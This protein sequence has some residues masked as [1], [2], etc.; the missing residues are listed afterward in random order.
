VSLH[1]HFDALI[2]A[3]PPD[4]CG[5]AGPNSYVET[6]NTEVSIYN[7]IT[8]ATIANDSLD[9]FFHTTG[10]I[11]RPNPY[12]FLSDATMCYDE[13][14]GRFVIADLDLDVRN[15][16]Q[17]PSLCA[18]AWS[19]TSNPT[20]LDTANWNFTYWTTSEGAAWSDYPGNIG[21]NHDAV[22]ITWNM[23]NS[24]HVRIDAL[25]QADMAANRAVYHT[26]YDTNLWN[27]RPVTMHDS[28]A[29]AGPM[30]FVT[31]GRT[32]S[33][34]EITL[35]RSDDILGNAI[36]DQ[37]FYIPVSH[38]D[39]AN[40]PL[41]PDG[42]VITTN[43]GG[44]KIL[45]AA[46]RNNTIVACHHIGVGTTENDARWYKFN[47]SDINHPY[48]VDQGNVSAGNHTYLMMPGI[49]I[50]AAG[51]V[52][53]S[54]IRSGTDSSTDYMSVWVTGRR[55]SDPAGTMQT[56][57]LVRAGTGN[58]RTGR[59][60][61]FSG[62][63]VDPNDG[64]FWV[65]NEYATAGGYNHATEVA[66]FAM[67]RQT[68]SVA[69]GQL[70][71]YGDQLGPNYNDYIAIDV[72][73]HGG[74]YANLNGEAAWFDP[75]QI[76]SILVVP[77]GGSNTVTV[78]NT[79]VPVD[80]R[81]SASDTVNLGN[82]SVQGIT[83]AVDI[84][85]PPTYDVLNINDSAD[86]A[87]H[88]NVAIGPG[89]ITG[90]A[91]AALNF[92][93]N[94]IGT[95]TV[96]GGSGN[97]T[98]TISDTPAHTSM[99]L[100]TGG[101][102]DTAYVRAAHVP[103]AVNTTTGNGGGGNDVV[104]IGNASHSLADIQAAVTVYN[105]PSRDQ[106]TIDDSADPYSHPNVAIGT[107]GITGLAPAALNFSAYSVD[108][109][110]VL[111]GGGA[112]T[113]TIS[114]TPANASMTLDTGAGVDTVNVQATSVPLTVIAGG[115]GSD[116]VN[117]GNANSLA[118]INGAL[119][120]DNPPSWSHVN[121]NDGADAGNHPNVTLTDTSLTGLAPATITFLGN[122][123]D[124]LTINGGS[125]TNTYTVVN[126]PAS[127]AP[128]GAPTT[129]NTGNGNDTVN[130][131]GTA[132]LM[133][134]TVHAGS[135]AD[136]VN[137]SP[138]AHNLSDIAGAVTLVGGGGSDQLAIHDEAYAPNTTYTLGGTPPSHTLSRNS[139]ALITYSG[140]T[141]AISIFGGSG[142]DTFVFSDTATLSGTLIGG[143]GSNTLDL[144]AYTTGLA[145]YVT[146]ADAGTIPGVLGAFFNVGNVTGGGG[147]NTFIFSDA[148][149]LS[150]MLDGGS[151]GSNTLDSS[152]YSTGESFTVNGANAG[153]G[154]PVAAFANI[155]NLVGAGAG[156]NYFSF[157]DGASLSGTLDGGSGGNNT[158]DSSAYTTSESFVIY[159]ANAGLGTPVGAFANIQT[160]I[161]GGGG[162]NSF[163]FSDGGSLDGSLNGGSG[164]GNTLDY[165]AGWTGNV[166][167]DLQTGAASGV[168]G[169]GAGAV[170]GIQNVVGASGGAAG[171]YN[172]LIGN[173]GNVLA[174]GTGRR[175]ILVAGG[176]ASTLLGGDNEDLLIGG[177][178]IYDTEAGLT[179]WQAI[180]AYWAGADDYGTRADNLTAGIGVPLLDAT[181]VIG[182]GGGNTMIGNGELALIYTDGLDNFTLGPPYP[183]GF[184]PNSR[185]VPIA[186]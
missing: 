154:T 143:G 80:I 6:V 16:G 5:A 29:V 186:P 94:S 67:N 50:N 144:S 84:E 120:L 79:N 172:L 52:G 160:L 88:P 163:A 39:N 177:T 82:G 20:A 72:N 53:M 12:V 101:G 102:A 115:N 35:Y 32:S 69:G 27:L 23:I 174:G 56:P 70:R 132:Y 10:G 13:I 63:N 19:K 28:T 3:N 54:Y 125:G 128:G 38:Y 57:V 7:K 64:T 75:G 179:S 62:I 92:S 11:P 149:T 2:G 134:L 137:L 43:T 170:T 146:G 46:E 133:P 117:V 108:T 59:Q 112:N 83:A 22:V 131:Q 66:N 93:A 107:G 61:D 173:G 161:G 48:L 181:T 183:P 41:N 157:A 47:V 168:A 74:V 105:N 100:D 14:I 18:F 25:S 171:T 71:I 130:V 182:N 45:N 140:F 90:L 151:G 165:S 184:D 141:G 33:N 78:Y 122:T 31:Y 139:A 30:W 34:N 180:A 152:A 68:F 145:V 86:A 97:N 89:G 60:G 24:T 164:A 118:G 127:G 77:Y 185:I 110:T 36:R 21:Y 148:T 129:L 81:S 147:N 17:A 96:L 156:G 113:Y 123:L 119:T 150:G 153:F 103:L 42:T 136:V 91:P 40:A 114:G 44:V 26:W 4:A 126:T 109:L 176:S 15:G 175:N 106:L 178:T 104:V 55:S 111:G 95:L 169:L 155:Q 8:S 138:T 166:L 121:I 142:N 167:V 135:G 87:S 51:D 162:G 99:T 37:S 158:L 85:N 1:N 9:H 76:T 116:V 73:P 124:G 58:E 98:Y 49:D 65:A 159:G